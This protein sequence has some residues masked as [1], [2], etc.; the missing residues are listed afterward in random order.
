MLVH[1]R[2]GQMVPVS[3]F[4]DV[5]QLL[6]DLR[7]ITD[8]GLGRK[9][10]LAQLALAVI[11]NFDPGRAPPGYGIWRFF[12]QLVSQMGAGGSH[13]GATEGDARHF[14]YRFLFVAGMAFQDLHTYDFRRTEMCIIPYGTQLGEISFCAYNTGVGW[15]YLTERMYGASAMGSRR[16]S[17]EAPVVHARLCCWAPACERGAAAGSQA[18][19]LRKLPVVD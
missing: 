2:S 6:S 12:R 4:V 17:S 3:D 19:A 15:R 5:E 9:W 10:T 13:V 11:K 8:A 7:Q 16:R 14:D 1:K 18:P